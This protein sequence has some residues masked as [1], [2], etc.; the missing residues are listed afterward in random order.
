MI[1]YF[2]VRS[3]GIDLNIQV[4]YAPIRMFL[5]KEIKTSL[6]FFVVWCKLFDLFNHLPH[7]KPTYSVTKNNIMKHRI[8]ELVKA[9]TLTA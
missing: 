7:A 3:C 6:Q 1:K 8:T 2:R 5:Y 4:S 9:E